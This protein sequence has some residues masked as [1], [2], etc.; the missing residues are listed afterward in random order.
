M[1]IILCDAI[2][3]RRLLRFIYDG[4]ERV[5]EPHQY[6]I[7]SANHEMLSCWL[8]GGWSRSETAPGWRNYLVHDMHD[9]HAL[10]ESFPGPRAGYNAE[11]AA[12]RQVYCRLEPEPRGDAA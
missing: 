7:N 9:I 2:G 12:F 3:A 8:V 1:N 11:D 4:Y 6:G 5:V 10:A